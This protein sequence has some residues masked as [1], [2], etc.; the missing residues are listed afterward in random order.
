MT[1]ARYGLAALLT[2]SCGGPL[3]KLP[4]GPGVPATDAAG[5]LREA[6]MACRAVSTFTSEI[7]VGGS[8][9]GR[10]VRGRLLAGLA[11]PA[12]VR[13]EAVAPLGQPLFFFVAR[14]EKTTVLLPR[15]NRVIEHGASAD[16]LDAVAGVPL[17]AAD[18]RIALT[19]CTAAS[20]SSSARQL[21]DNWRVVSNGPSEIYLY[22]DA[23]AKPW[24]L[25]AAVRR[26]A[27]HASWRAEYRDFVEGLPRTVRLASVDE[28]RFD[29]R[30][31]LS[32]V[33]VN[34]PLDAAAFTLRIPAGAR[35]ITLDELKRSGPLA[36]TP[37]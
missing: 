4:A 12:S 27:G 1:F 22:R 3:V 17:G 34:E 16:V 11:V 18:L 8:V 6:T 13:L 21:G 14:D 7:S 36:T 28:A 30:L 9:G 25:V 32:Q 33:A 5:A 2:A 23:H 35:P 29:L 10:R 24:R 31:T 20:D 15:E 37:P 19:A 26:D